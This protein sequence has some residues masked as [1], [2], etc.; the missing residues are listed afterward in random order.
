MHIRTRANMLKT[1]PPIVNPTPPPTGVWRSPRAK[2]DVIEPIFTAKFSQ[3]FNRIP[4]YSP[5]M[6]FQEAVNYISDKVY[7]KD[8]T[9]WMPETFITSSPSLAPKNNSEVDIE[10]FVLLS[11]TQSQEKPSPNTGSSSRIIKQ[12]TFDYWHWRLVRSLETWRRGMQ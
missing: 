1:V 2:A 9:T 11:Y 8:P 4:V 3:S 10:Y 5:N 6:I 12:K 7:N